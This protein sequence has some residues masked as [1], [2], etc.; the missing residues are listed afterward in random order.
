MFI[1]LLWAL[2][3][4][5]LQRK[6]PEATRLNF[7]KKQDPNISKGFIFY[8]LEKN[9]NVFFYLLSWT[10]L[11]VASA[12]LITRVKRSLEIVHT[13]HCTLLWNKHIFYS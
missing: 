3:A 12:N 10:A 5:K 8:N 1:D 6:T 7:R 9:T 13:A 11:Q 2:E 4:Q